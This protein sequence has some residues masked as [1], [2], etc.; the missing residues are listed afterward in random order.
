MG[1][2][3]VASQVLVVALAGAVLWFVL[4]DHSSAIPGG[5]EGNAP[6]SQGK[7]VRDP[8][9]SAVATLKDPRLR[10]LLEAEQEKA[11]E[12]AAPYV[13]ERLLREPLVASPYSLIDYHAVWKELGL[14]DDQK[15]R[16]ADWRRETKEAR[17][18][19]TASPF[20]PQ[21]ISR[22]S[23]EEDRK[24]KHKVFQDVFHGI[25]VYKL[26]T[27]ESILDAKQNDRL[28]ELFYQGAW[29]GT[30]FMMA[31]AKTCQELGISAEQVAQ[32]AKIQKKHH[33]E[34]AKIRERYLG[35]SPRRPVVR[36]VPPKSEPAPR[37]S[38]EEGYE[39]MARAE[40]A[41]AEIREEDRKARADMLDVLTEV[42]RSKFAEMKG[43]PFDFSQCTHYSDEQIAR[44]KELREEKMMELQPYL[45]RLEAEEKNGAKN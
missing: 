13:I 14:S 39:R 25:S 1:R 23:S 38:E 29:P 26:E 32:I 2:S 20:S 22:Q 43:E 36:P 27:L 19:L 28:R 37:R 31:E 15:A 9:N 17:E 7:P 11:L 41:E 12:K 16:I 4:R 34:V 45:D 8:S 40:K 5:S 3:S 35:I 10:E 33:A 44:M 42:Q 18:W 24:K 30:L 6:P 21:K